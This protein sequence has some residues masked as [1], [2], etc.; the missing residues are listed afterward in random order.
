MPYHVKAAVN[1][2][3]YC[4]SA[5]INHYE[6]FLGEKCSRA[7]R[8]PLCPLFK[9]NKLVILR[10]WR[11]ICNKSLGD[12]LLLVNRDCVFPKPPRTQGTE[13]SPAV[14]DM[15]VACNRAGGVTGRAL[16]NWHWCN[17]PSAALTR[18]ALQHKVTFLHGSALCC[19]DPSARLRLT[20][21]S[22][23]LLFCT[24]IWPCSRIGFHPTFFSFRLFERKTERVICEFLGAYG[25][26]YYSDNH[27]RNKIYGQRQSLL[28]SWL[29]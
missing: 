5:Y 19:T 7:W 17:R 28:L 10:A 25:S 12:F 11:I 14:C 9:W 22:L 4:S 27:Q 24:G 2:M 16:P 13:V 21:Q 8:E 3:H 26:K 23:T 15:S 6:I 1:H 29:I 20:W 18:L